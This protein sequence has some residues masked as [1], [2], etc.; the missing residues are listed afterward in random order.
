MSPRFQINYGTACKE[1]GFQTLR[2]NIG[3]ICTPYSTGPNYCVEQGEQCDDGNL[4]KEDGCD[5]FCILEYTCGDGL[6][7]GSE[8]C[9]DGN[10]I[11]GDGCSTECIFD[12]R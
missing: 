9:D 10:D 2:H 12:G 7:Q 5:E 4:E 8:E 6:V 3:Q 1:R 11:N